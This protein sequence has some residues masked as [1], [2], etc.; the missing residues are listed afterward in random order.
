M[1]YDEGT[2][3]V[4]GIPKIRSNEGVISFSLAK[5]DF[6]CQKTVLHTHCIFFFPQ[7]SPLRLS[8][9]WEMYASLKVI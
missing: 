9:V 1:T 3:I 5:V 4:L 8:L 7:H 6:D 2:A